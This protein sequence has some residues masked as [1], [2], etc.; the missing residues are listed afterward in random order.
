MA[1][2]HQHGTAFGRVGSRTMILL[3]TS[4]GLRDLLLRYSAINVALSASSNE[5]EGMVIIFS[6]N[7]IASSQYL[8][9]LPFYPILRVVPLSLFRLRACLITTSDTPLPM[10]ANAFPVW[11]SFLL[12][13]Y[14]LQATLRNN[15]SDPWNNRGFIIRSRRTPSFSKQNIR[16]TSYLPVIAMARVDAIVSALVLSSDPCRRVYGTKTG[17][18]LLSSRAESSSLPILRIDVPHISEIYRFR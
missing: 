9:I 15:L 11:E 8:P 18:I 10:A 2:E 14:P 4:C 7:K 16:R 3:P 5:S 17:Q 1:V 13:L 6:R 12:Q